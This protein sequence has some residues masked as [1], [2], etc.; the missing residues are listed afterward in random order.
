MIIGR[1]RFFLLGEILFLT[2]IWGT[3]I[4]KKKEDENPNGGTRIKINKDPY[5]KDKIADKI[6]A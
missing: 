2:L 4:P 6:A 1:G 3:I 5:K